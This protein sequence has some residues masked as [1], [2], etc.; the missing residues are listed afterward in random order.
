MTNFI[1]EAFKI[2]CGLVAGILLLVSVTAGV[3]YVGTTGGAW[4]GW[5]VLIGGPLLV[6]LMFGS[7]ALVIQ[8]N[9]LLRRIA[10]NQEK[11]VP[12]RGAQGADDGAHREPALRAER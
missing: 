6:I 2:V 3:A 1:A 9:Q 12:P 8:N 4:Q 5:A 11:G 10:E 7:L